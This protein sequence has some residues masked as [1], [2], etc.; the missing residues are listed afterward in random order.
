MLA[1]SIRLSKLLVGVIDRI[2]VTPITVLVLLCGFAYCAKD[3]WSAGDDHLNF[4]MTAQAISDKAQV[5][6]L[7]GRAIATF[8]DLGFREQGIESVAVRQKNLLNY[9]LPSTL[10]SI[11][12]RLV[13]A[14]SPTAIAADYASYWVDA[15]QL[16]YAFALLV[17]GG[18]FIFALGGCPPALRV[19]TLLALAAMLL[20]VVLVPGSGY[21]RLGG[22]FLERL[23]LA[24]LNPGTA[25]G[26]FGIVP[27]NSF[28]LLA[29]A[30]FVLRMSGRY[31][32]AYALLA[33]ACLFHRQQG[34]LLLVLLVFVD[35]V[36]RPRLLADLRVALWPAAGLSYFAAMETLWAQIG[37]SRVTGL[38]VMLGF[39]AAAFALTALFARGG[40]GREV[41]RGLLGLDRL[42]RDDRV[43][44]L[45]AWLGITLI[46]V[47]AASFG[48]RG[49]Y[50]WE[51]LPARLL[52]ILQPL[53][54]LTLIQRATR[55]LLAARGAWPAGR[56]WLMPLGKGVAA[57][58]LAVALLNSA[59]DVRVRAAELAPVLGWF[60]ER[61]DVGVS[62]TV[63]YE[64]EK[65]LYFAIVRSVDTGS[66]DFDGLMTAT[67]APRF[68]E[69]ASA[70]A[71]GDRRRFDLALA[72]AERLDRAVELSTPLR[73]PRPVARVPPYIG[74][75]IWEREDLAE[76]ISSRM[77]GRLPPVG[78]PTL[79]EAV[80]RGDSKLLNE[81]SLLAPAATLD[82]PCLG[83]AGQ[84]PG[85]PICLLR[86][87]GDWEA[88]ERLV[89]AG[90]SPDPVGG[91]PG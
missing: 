14:L 41:E 39:A 19:Q 79:C 13:E 29:L 11:A 22:G 32:A 85:P 72:Q 82:Q 55:R 28:V 35:L 58:G 91:C 42:F 70:I 25:Y 53:L 5:D 68:G 27:R 80:A 73:W 66:G 12:A 4:F 17:A 90:A 67:R 83:A 31:A 6:H 88:A 38:A 37:V 16:G 71:S 75:L 9:L 77:G 89:K 40:S 60:G 30:A 81:L 49:A 21:F 61:L 1:N 33:A 56:G 54:V 48:L 24:L 20:I 8:E 47:A 69:L 43:V 63:S 15:S 2:G 65:R 10:Y 46:S 87:R 7:L 62:A 74:A 57:A 26:P 52:I 50:F 34:A 59:S 3:Y 51:L 18:L 64:D 45:C 84:E 86:R 76:A 78:S 23:P 44:L 36:M